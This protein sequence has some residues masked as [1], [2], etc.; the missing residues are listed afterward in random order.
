MELRVLRQPALLEPAL[1]AEACPPYNLE[2]D[3]QTH[4]SGR[5]VSKLQGKAP[6]PYPALYTAKCTQVWLGRKRS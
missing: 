4:S 3:S 5:G 6:F 1:A 2:A